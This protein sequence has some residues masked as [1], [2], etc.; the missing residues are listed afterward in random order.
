[1]TGDRIDAVKQQVA[2]HWN[3]RAPSFDDDFGHSIRTTGERAAWDRILDLVLDGRARLEALD[4]GCGTGFLALEL[5][6]R[7]HHVVGVD[8]APAMIEEARRKAAVSGLS[9]RFEEADAEQL[10]FA[11]RSFDL[12]ISRHVLW[13]LPRPQA[14]IDEWTRV[15]RPDGRLAV[16]DGQF[17]TSGLGRSS[18]IAR[19]SEEC[20]AIRCSTSWRLRSSGWSRRDGR[21]RPIAATSSG[22][23]PQRSGPGRRDSAAGGV[24]EGGEEPPR[25]LEAA[26]EVL[27]VPLHSHHEAGVVVELHA[28]YELIGR[29]R[30]RLQPA[31]ERL[32]H[33]VMEAVDLDVIDAEHL[34]EAAAGSDADLVRRLITRRLLAVLDLRPGLRA[35]VLVEGAAER[36]VEHLDAAA[37]S[38]ERRL[39]LE[40][41]VR[42]RRLE[43]IARRRHVVERRMR[44][45]AEARG[46]H[47]ATAREKNGVEATHEPRQGRGGELRGEE[48]G[49]AARLLHRF[50]IRGIDVGALGR[51]ADGDRRGDAD[52]QFTRH[53]A[54]LPYAA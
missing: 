25:G 26:H 41:H 29:P 35:H 6:A 20:A 22:V 13:T 51:L 50:E 3:R 44:R 16:V 28:L 45:L 39:L 2:T 8:F 33:L 40:R 36:D 1:M 34:G 54:M 15:L 38:E 42:H 21:S 18:G 48:H 17:D 23:T 12:G 30:H 43:R 46:I 47:V 11:P 10:P 32:D 19:A 4:V 52:Q 5:A 9:A 49:H 53:A 24:D 7:G 27:G 37:N 14:A 31:A